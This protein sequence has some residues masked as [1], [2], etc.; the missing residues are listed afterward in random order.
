MGDLENSFLR[1]SCLL[2]FAQFSFRCF[3]EVEKGERYLSLESVQEVRRDGTIL[4]ENR[5]TVQV[6]GDR[7]K[8]G[9]RLSFLT[10]Y[11]GPGNLVLRKRVSDIELFR[12]GE[13]EPFHESKGDGHLS[14][15][16]GEKNV[17]LEPGV[18]EYDF[19]C[20]VDGDWRIAGGE[21]VG[22]FDVSGPFQGFSIESARLI[23]RF[24]EGI[25]VKKHAPAV[26]GS[27]GGMPGY[28]VKESGAELLV[29]TTSPLA[30]NHSFEVRA[31]W[32]AAGFA[33]HSRWGE[34]LRQHP[35]LL[36][37]ALTA[38]VLFWILAILVVRLVRSPGKDGENSRGAGYCDPVTFSIASNTIPVVTMPSGRAIAFFD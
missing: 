15:F 13:P 20:V 27:K 37:T 26:F 11:R 3:H 5:F 34:V 29:S 28:E 35:K 1:A 14:I 25:R 38:A 8:R 10:A 9:P 18:H 6:D 2:F 16:C 7:I 31:I 30:E 17:I 12:N 21:A 22:S 33:T 23:L 4:I 24:P 19:R 32:P 36:I